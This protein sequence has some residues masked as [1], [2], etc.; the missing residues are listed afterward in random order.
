MDDLRTKTEDEVRTDAVISRRGFFG[1]TVGL[2]GAAGVLLA[3]TG[4]P[5]GDG[6]DD[7]GDDG[8]DDD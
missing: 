4:C 2:A 1:R 8:D 6:D 7:D 3:L 5:G